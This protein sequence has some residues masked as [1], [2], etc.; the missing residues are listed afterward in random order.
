MK[1]CK[2]CGSQ[3]PEELFQP[4]F[5]NGGYITNLCPICVMTK[6]NEFH[7]LPFGTLPTGDMASQLVEDA[8]QYYKPK[9][10]KGGKHE[11]NK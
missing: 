5:I 2:E 10:K 8:W 4:L 3:M 1:T 6:R 7:G 9:E 11:T